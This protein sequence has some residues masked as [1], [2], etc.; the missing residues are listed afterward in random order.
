MGQ[1]AFERL[2]PDLAYHSRISG[3]LE[4]ILNSRVQA[5]ALMQLQ[6]AASVQIINEK[7]ASIG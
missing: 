7:R 6:P 1:I 3:K 2:T 4:V 5:N